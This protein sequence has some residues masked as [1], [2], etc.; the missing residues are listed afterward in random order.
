MIFILNQYDKCRNFVI[1]LLKNA[2]VFPDLATL[3]TYM[4]KHVLCDIDYLLRTCLDKSPLT[5]TILIKIRA[6][7]CLKDIV[8]A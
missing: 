8:R 4:C 6:N 2:H 1:D 7:H 3:D 5:L